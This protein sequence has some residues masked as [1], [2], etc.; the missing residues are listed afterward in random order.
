MTSA[1]ARPN[2]EATI[3]ETAQSLV[4][5]FV[6]AMTFRGFVTEG[7]VIPTGSMAPTLMG[8]HAL[9]HG[10]QTGSDFPVGL[11]TKPAPVP[12][13]SSVQDPK[14]GPRFRGSGGI[15]NADDSDRRMGDRIL[16][17]KN[18]LPFMGPK[19]WD[20][21]VF[22]N[23]TDPDGPSANYIKRLIGMPNEMVWLADGD[24]FVA[25]TDVDSEEVTYTVRR[26]PEHVQRAVWQNIHHS[27]FI[28]ADPMQL[29]QT[30][31]GAPWQGT[32]W[33][34]TTRVYR[35]TSAAASRLHWESKVRQIDDWTSYNTARA[36][37]GFFNVADLRIGATLKATDPTALTT[38]AELTARSHRFEWVINGSAGTV[39]LRMSPMDDAASVTTT[40]PIDIDI[41][42]PDEPINVEFWHVD[43][44]L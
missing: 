7:F 38:R 5:A 44:R 9:L 28:P 21:T 17:L 18:L 39:E 43:Q 19:R 30:Y 36:T 34:T 16:V 31:R 22:K 2:H 29:D 8:Q 25:P 41:P 15:Q 12:D 33:D 13:L 3:V 37:R 20:V 10:D 6:L 32:G 11:P 14:I 35:C 27:D 26:K 24:V 4:V 42:G 1:A 40:G 23:P